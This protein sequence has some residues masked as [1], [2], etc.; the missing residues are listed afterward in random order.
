M[1]FGHN[2]SP[3]VQ[4]ADEVSTERIDHVEHLAEQRAGRVV[5]VPPHVLAHAVQLTLFHS[6]HRHVLLAAE[7][8]KNRVVVVVAA[9]GRLRLQAQ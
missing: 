7:L 8:A 2:N 4:S 1:E 6:Q 3:G 9:T 5:G